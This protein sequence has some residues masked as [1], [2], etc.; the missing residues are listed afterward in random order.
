[1]IPH[2]LLIELYPVG[3]SESIEAK[4]RLS[5]EVIMIHIA[6]ILG[7]IGLALF[8]FEKCMPQE[9]HV[10]RYGSYVFLALAV[11]VYLYHMLKG[12]NML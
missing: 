10:A 4:K 5:G 6:L 1:L 7:G 11:L 3:F 8:L 2:R 12:A 9:I